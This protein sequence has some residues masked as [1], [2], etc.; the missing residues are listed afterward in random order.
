MSEIKAFKKE[1]TIS[2]TDPLSDHF[3]KLFNEMKTHE[4]SLLEC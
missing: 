4:E 2:Q 3:A 1:S